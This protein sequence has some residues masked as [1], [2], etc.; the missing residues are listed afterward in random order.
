[1]VRAHDRAMVQAPHSRHPPRK[2]N[3]DAH[4]H[5]RHRRQEAPTTDGPVRFDDDRALA[6]AVLGGD[7]DAFRILVDREAAAVLAVCRRILGDP[8]D[9]E[10]AAQE[11]FLLAYRKLGTYRAEGPLGGWLM[12]I[13]IREARDR[14]M[15]RPSTEPWHLDDE[16]LSGSELAAARLAAD[17]PEALAESGELASGLRAAI[18]DLPQHYRD[19]V[20]GRYM[21][22]L[23]FA[24]IALATG[25]PEPTVR[26]HAHRGLARLRA[27]LGKEARP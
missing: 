10:D 6:D 12:R 14:A 23:S 17:G 21:D 3:D 2:G 13:A 18:A 7:R 5:P 16:P 27:R 9:A 8:T 26:T 24:E 11:A 20:R 25:R 15:R 19:A 1:M 22:D 4:R